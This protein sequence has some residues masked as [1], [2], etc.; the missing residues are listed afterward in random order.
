[1][2]KNKNKTK[3]KPEKNVYNIQYK[4]KN[5]NKI[6]HF[7]SLLVVF[8]PNENIKKDSNQINF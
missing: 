7:C 6:G 1:M 8:T 4:N 5:W 3:P 2:N